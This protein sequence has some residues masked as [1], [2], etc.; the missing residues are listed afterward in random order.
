M[1]KDFADNF[2]NEIV[3]SLKIKSFPG[4]F[5]YLKLRNCENFLLHSL[6]SYLGFKW[7][8]SCTW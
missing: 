6:H 1:I 4:S 7:H 8:F 2:W 3:K 5:A